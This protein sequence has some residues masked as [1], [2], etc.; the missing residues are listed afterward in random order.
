[1]EA[2]VFNEDLVGV[3]AGNYHAGEINSG[4]VALAG[5]RMAVGTGCSGI[6]FNADAAQEIE[7]GMVSGERVHVI[8]LNADA[9]SL[10]VFNLH[11]VRRDLF[12]AGFHVSPDGTFLDTVFDVR[13]NPVFDVPAQF[14]LAVDHGDVSSVPEQVKR[15]NGR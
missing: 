11:G 13:A 8:V 7:V 5:F 9:L 2:A 10:G 15:R 4:N 14:K 6:D 3:P 1:M 12:N